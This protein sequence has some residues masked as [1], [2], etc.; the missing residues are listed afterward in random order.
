MFTHRGKQEA[1]VE[2]LL[3]RGLETLLR[4]QNVLSGKKNTLP[5]KFRSILVVQ[6]MFSM[7]AHPGKHEETLIRNMFPVCPGLTRIILR[8][9]KN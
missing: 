2:E 7:F 8:D 3:N 4:K 6:T 9:M 1:P 5:K